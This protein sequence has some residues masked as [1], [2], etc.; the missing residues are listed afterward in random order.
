VEEST[1][2]EVTQLY[3]GVSSHGELIALL[4]DDGRKAQPVVVFAPRQ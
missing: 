1:A 4:K 3:A 2:S